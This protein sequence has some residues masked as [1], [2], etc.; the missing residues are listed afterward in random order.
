MHID[1]FYWWPYPVRTKIVDYI[2]SEM[3]Q[4]DNAPW[5][6]NVRDMVNEL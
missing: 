6:T 1:Y 3:S 5:S 4:F 2:V